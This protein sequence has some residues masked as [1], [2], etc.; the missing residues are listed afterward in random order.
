MIGS[1]WTALWLLANTYYMALD[2]KNET[3]IGYRLVSVL[4]YCHLYESI[5]YR[6]HDYNSSNSFVLLP[7]RSLALGVHVLYFQLGTISKASPSQNLRIE[8]FQLLSCGLLV[9][10]NNY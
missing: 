3:T 5:E 10:K 2:L 8:N 6:S 1:Y 4:H 7:G 9:L